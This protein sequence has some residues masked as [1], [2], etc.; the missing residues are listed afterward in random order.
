M[1]VRARMLIG[2][3]SVVAVTAG[4]APA[5]AS[6]VTATLGPAN[7]TNPN[8]PG[9]TVANPATSG[10]AL[11]TLTPPGGGLL[12]PPTDGTITSWQVNGSVTGGGQLFL[13]VAHPDGAGTYA[14]TAASP[15]VSGPVGMTSYPAGNIPIGRGDTISV[16][17][18]APGPGDSAT[19][20]AQAFPGRAW[21]LINND[22]GTTMQAPFSPT[23]D[24]QLL[25]NATVELTRPVI[26]S[27]SPRSGPIAGG[28][29]VTI[30]GDHFAETTEVRFGAGF[31]AQSFSGN[32]TSITAVSPPGFQ[33]GPEDVYVI[34][35]AGPNDPTEASRFEYT[36]PDR[37]PPEVSSFRITPT[38]FRAANSG[39]SILLRARTTA[40]VTYT[41]S[42]PASASFSVDRVLKGR[43]V[44]KSCVKPKPSNKKKRPCRRYVP[45]NG[46][47]VQESIGG[48][49]QFK[50]SGRVTGKKLRPGLYRLVVAAA[51]AA[52][53][54]SKPV[55]A[56][57]RIVKK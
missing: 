31:Q 22:P 6:A 3:L 17:A 15:P 52:G 25:Y 30:T 49:N 56:N 42:E 40:T 57:F 8:M 9:F 34:T 7:L 37:T 55:W 38:K 28:T 13:Q 33:E 24:Q 20:L 44:G 54:T 43:R 4:M 12:V 5:S 53:N 26:S 29:E 1:R 51:D 39:D 18:S 32:N 35:A 48:V 50:F 21:S 46:S 2:V 47:F 41:L 19:V 23:A 10:G 45:V 11:N 16:R 14:A 36:G 27:I